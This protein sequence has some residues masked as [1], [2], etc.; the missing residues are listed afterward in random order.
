[1]KRATPP[2]PAAAPSLQRGG[3][4]SVA[5]VLNVLK[6]LA[7]ADNGLTLTQLSAATGSP[8]TSLLALLRGLTDCSFVTQ[9]DTAYLLGPESF[10]LAPG[11]VSRMKFPLVARPVLEKLA[12]DSGETILVAEMSQ[13][14][15]HAVYIEKLEGTRAVRFIANVGESRPLYASAGGRVLLAFQDEAFQTAYLSGN[16]LEPLNRKKRIT[17]SE[18]RRLLSDIRDTRLAITKEDVTEG[19]AG[20]AS[21]IFGE[22]GCVIVAL[23]IGAPISRG[24]RDANFLSNLVKSAAADI[25]RA[26]GYTTGARPGARH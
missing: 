5:R 16:T 13:D 2:D 4:R 19:V 7:A 20:F 25:S 8:K 12:Q 11:I 24:L 26:F 23:I 10:A 22:D 14:R 15:R 3:P 21:P 9:R 17:R 1:M 6:L 18:L